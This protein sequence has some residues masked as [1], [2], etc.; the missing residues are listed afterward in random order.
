[1]YDLNSTINTFYRT[2][3]RLGPE[4]RAELANY[5]DVN[6]A[7][8][9]DGLDKLGAEKGKPY[10][11]PIESLTQGGYAMHTLN[12]HPRNEY[13]IDVAVIFLREDLPAYALEARKRVADAFLKAGGNFSKPPEARTNAVTVWYAEGYHIDFAI[14]RQY[15]N[16]MGETV[17]EHAGA[18]WR[19]ADPEKVTKWFSTEV[20]RLSPGQEL[21][22]K[23]EAG[24][25]RKVVRL[26]KAFGKSRDD[27][28]LPGGMILSAL[29][30]E[31]Y[32]PDWYRDDVAFYNTLL[33]I[34]DRLALT[35][36]VTNPVYPDQK[37]TS[38][39]EYLYQVRNLRNKLDEAVEH[40]AVL[41]DGE[42][43]DASAMNAWYW[44]FQ[45]EFWRVEES[46]GGAEHTPS[47][48]ARSRRDVRESPPFA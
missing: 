5:R 47:L 26:L 31:R 28:H 48:L 12:Q 30:A 17:L 44:V 9:N 2:H 4:R 41:S 3:V 22:A 18:D 27:W 1:M 23:V 32:A 34:R 6:L 37:L 16:Q 35:E 38:K 45:H 15:E 21:G 42:C 25:M 36:E 13:D 8:L 40:L 24:Q 46:E 43:T 11:H 10:A 33:A 39:P 20:K 19:A 7:R 29:V 14:Y